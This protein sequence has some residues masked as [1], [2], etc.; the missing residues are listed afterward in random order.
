[1]ELVGKQYASL[2]LRQMALIVERLFHQKWNFFVEMVV[3]Y[4]FPS[5]VVVLVDTSRANGVMAFSYLDHL[6]VISFRYIVPANHP[7]YVL[8]CK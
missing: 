7:L 1:M 5:M 6:K 4:L 3:D 8:C 2:R